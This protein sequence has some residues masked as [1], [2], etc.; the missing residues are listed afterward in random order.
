MSQ[1][2]KDGIVIGS[3]IYMM[4]EEKAGF[5]VSL[6]VIQLLA[7]IIGSYSM[8]FIFL[9]CFPLPVKVSA[10]GL[11]VL[12]SSATFFLLFLYPEYDL[13]KLSASAAIYLIILWRRFAHLQNGF[14]ILENSVIKRAASYYGFEMFRYK[15][16]YGRDT[17]DTTLL[18]IMAA[19][20]ITAVIAAAAIRSRLVNLCCLLLVLP[21]AA[22]FAV[23]ITPREFWLVAS[24]II[25]L[26][27]TR[28]N[29]IGKKTSYKE[30]KFL[31]HRINN[32]SAIVLC[33]FALALFL[34]AK[35][36]IPQEK[37]DDMDMIVET[38]AKF[39][40]F[41][42]SFSLEDLT[43]RFDDLSIKVQ[44]DKKTGTGGLSSGKLGQFDHVTY[45][46]TEHLK[47]TVPI[48]SITEGIYLKGYVGSEYTGS[49]WNGHTKAERESYQKIQDA[50]AAETHYPVNLSTLLLKEISRT[51]YNPGISKGI[52]NFEFY[53]GTISIKYKAANE[54]YIYAP[55]LTDFAASGEAKYSTD[56]YAAPIKE[57]SSYDFDY[58]YGISAG[59]GIEQYLQSG[60]RYRLEY[61][62]A[63]KLYRKYVY[64]TYTK[65]PEKGLD[66]LK[67]DFSKAVVGTQAKTLSGAISYIKNYLHGSTE[68]TLSPGRLPEG[69]DFAEY[70]I[71]ENK[72]GYCT[73]YASAG[74]LMLRAMGY[75]ARYV[76]GYAVSPS[77]IMLNGPVEE[78]RTTY[79][80]KQGI[81]LTF[82]NQV[83]V[84]V[85]DYNAHAWVEVYIDGCGWFPVEFTPSAGI[86]GANEVVGDMETIS[87]GMVDQDVPEPTPAAKLPE[88]TEAPAEDE[89]N[90]PT[91]SQ[92]P[93]D[94]TDKEGRAVNT[95]EVQPEKYGSG[96]WIITAL[97]I[98]FAAAVLFVLSRV[99]VMLWYK[100]WNAADL[101][102]KALLLYERTERILAAC[103]FLP[104][105][106]RKEKNLED[107]RD[108]VKEHCPY[109]K[110]DEFDTCME[111]VEKAR[112]G[113]NTISREEY[114]TVAKFYRGFYRKAYKN[115][116]FF[117]KIRMKIALY[118]L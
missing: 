73:H 32:R 90:A 42:Y 105:L 68:Y 59:L 62:E 63:E 43:D 20:I 110:K 22:S 49:S 66:R 35:L 2:G 34:A 1:K 117:R 112:F 100:R 39:Q 91:V 87:E 31:L 11:A 103:R 5:P 85:K 74:A 69:K 12:L 56:L 40:D 51:N 76:E 92:P 114:H 88:P 86:T 58:Y 18:I 109:M 81:F 104:K 78:Q 106:P 25:M 99:P 60:Y 82:D 9:G 79:Y 94:V 46:E 36:F 71:Y 118:I 52:D 64:D 26:F 41:L 113:R 98:I 10:V 80:S 27:I 37:Y 17:S 29:V 107:H 38:K 101:S 89:G 93:K 8:T 13:I 70:F 45:D 83:E 33:Q 4:D 57:K 19:I 23:G 55:Y 14:Y 28:S 16:D 75:P 65:L 54:G 67:Q 84:S 108:Y 21:I 102:K 61:N 97:L 96:K 111:I 30:R 116:A 72:A 6:R 53:K 24:I 115:S 15:A 95:G 48:T 47:I 44:P 77:D 7:I 3:T 50:I